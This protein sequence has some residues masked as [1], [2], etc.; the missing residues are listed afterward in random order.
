MATDLYLHNQHCY[1]C[2]DALNEVQ[3]VSR[4]ATSD[5]VLFMWCLKQI[6]SNSDLSKKFNNNDTQL[7]GIDFNFLKKLKRLWS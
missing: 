7:D 4:T 3:K 6:L 2:N 5:I 1:N